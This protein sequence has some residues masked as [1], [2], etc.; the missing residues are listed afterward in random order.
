MAEKLCVFC[1][2]WRM[3]GGD[4]GYSELTPGW[5]AEMSC[6]KNLWTAPHWKDKRRT[7]II[8]LIDIYSA[9]TFRQIIE[10]AKSCPEY[11]QVES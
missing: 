4:A 11:Q 9:D 8:R 7:R 10:K 3:T 6:S 1:E 5:D 2:H